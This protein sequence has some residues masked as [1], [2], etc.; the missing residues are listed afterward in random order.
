MCFMVSSVRARRSDAEFLIMARTPDN[1][2]SLFE[3]LAGGLQLVT[4]LLRALQP[5]ADHTRVPTMPFFAV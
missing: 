2:G 3:G 1:P 5:G 4:S